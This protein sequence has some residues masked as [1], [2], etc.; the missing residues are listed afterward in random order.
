MH[1]CN[2]DRKTA[3]KVAKTARPAIDPIGDFPQLLAGLAKAQHWQAM[4]KGT[5]G[6]TGSRS[7]S[8][9]TATSGTVAAG[10][11]LEPEP[12]PTL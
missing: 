8:S 5:A 9:G 4:R 6:G 7:G 12:E 10:G 2:L 1:L 11:K 3:T